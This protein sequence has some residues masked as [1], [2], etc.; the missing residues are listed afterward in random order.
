[1]MLGGL[2]FGGFHVQVPADGAFQDLW[3][4]L[5]L[6]FGRLEDGVPVRAC[7]G[8]EG[9][10][11]VFVVG[12]FGGDHQ[13]LPFSQL[14]GEGA[15]L[16]GQVGDPLAELRNLLPRGQGELGALLLGGG[17]GLGGA[18]RREL[19]AGVPAAQFAVGGDGQL[20]LLAG[21]G[22]PLLPVG[23]DGGEDGLAFG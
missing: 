12:V 6:G 14:A 16:G 2:S 7:P 21:G 15:V 10:A 22:L 13:A 11:E 1:M 5:D 19:L 23:H 4:R 8:G 17:L 18:Q 9:R 20:P 3:R